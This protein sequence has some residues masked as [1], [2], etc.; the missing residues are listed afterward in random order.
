MTCA[1]M[2]VGQQRSGLTLLSS[3]GAVEG[4]RRTVVCQD[5]HPCARAL[6][7]QPGGHPLAGHAPPSGLPAPTS[8]EAVGGGLMPSE[9]T[10]RALGV[11][12]SA[13]RAPTAVGNPSPST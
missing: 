8:A 12:G 7:A 10:K 2:I 3:T 11:G 5:R 4:Q 6:G 9:K 1:P 13:D